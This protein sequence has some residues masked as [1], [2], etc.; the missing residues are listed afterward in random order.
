[1]VGA[2]LA[3][4]RPT[5]PVGWLLLG[6]AVLLDATGA[7]AAYGP[8]GLLARPGAVVVGCGVRISGCGGCRRLG[9][10]CLSATGQ[11]LQESRE[12]D[13]RLVLAAAERAVPLWP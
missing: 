4:R 9:R 7:A 10:S 8:Y 11:Q 2:V 5:H 13:A 1:M 6:L 3:S 12:V